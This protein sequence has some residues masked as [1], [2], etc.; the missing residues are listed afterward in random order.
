MDATQIKRL[1]EERSRAVSELRALDSR[2]E[3]KEFDAEAKATEERLNSA[4]ADFDGRI[5]RGLDGIEAEKRAEADRARLDALNPGARGDEG[6]N[7]QAATERRALD[8]FLKGE[9]RAFESMPLERRDLTVGTATDGAELVPTTLYA[10][11]V[12]HFIETSAAVRAGATV[13]QTASGEDIVVPKTTSYSTAA[14]VGEGSAISESDPQFST[15]T[16]EAYKYAFMV[17]VSSELLQDSAFDVE[18]FLAR[19]GGV[20]LG[21]GMGGHFATGTGSSQPNGIVT[22]STKGADFAA[23]AITVDNLIDLQ[24]SVIEPYRSRGAWLLKDATVAY[25]RKLKDSDGQY[26]WQPA[27]TAGA[28]DTLL[29]RPVVTDPAVAAIGAS[30]KSVLFGDFSGYFV[31]L[32]GGVRIERSVD[33]AFANDLVTVRFIA[34]GD[35]D[36]VDTNA[37]KHGLHAAS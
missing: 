33:Y 25:V 21:H 20:A 8:A 24:H 15:V 3:G 26:L 22:A 7:D 16:L 17:Q 36:L 13:I 2:F 1:F 34:R 10:R 6:R 27:I 31:R 11:L 5:A 23:A 9:A 4:I 19:Q 29:G 32:A 14:I 12:E 35:G 18:A 37:V 30:A 28:P